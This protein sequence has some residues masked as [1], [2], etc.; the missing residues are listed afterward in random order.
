MLWIILALLLMISQMAVV[1]INEYCRPQKAVAWLVLLYVFPLVGFVAYGFVAKEYSRF[2]PANRKVNRTL[3]P[4]KEQIAK[5]CMRRMALEPVGPPG[6]DSLYAML[7]NQN[8][9]PITAGNQ[10]TVYSEGKEAFEAMFESLS[11]AK[12]H[13]HIEFYII[14][15]DGLGEKFQQLLIRKS[16][17]GVKVRLLYDGIGCHRLRKTY[18]QE[19]QD[20]GVETGC[21]APPLSAFLNKRINYRNHRKIVVVDGQVGFIGG[22]N[23]G[24]EYLGKNA[25]T[26]YWRD[27]HFKIQGDAALWIQY[28][29]AKDWFCVKRRLLTDPVYY[30]VQPAQ[31]NELIQIIKSGP[32]ET[33]LELIFTFVASAKKRIYIETPYFVPDSG[34]LLALK[35]AAMRGVDVRIVIPAVPDTKLVYWA[36]LSYVQ[37]MLDAG[38]RVYRYQKGFIHAKVIL[39]DDVACAGSAN[40]DMRSFTGQYEINAMF[41]DDQVVNRLHADFFCDLNECE[42]IKPEEFG[43]RPAS[44]KAKETFARLLSA[45]F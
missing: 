38:V 8:F 44:L 33:I 42:E 31:G 10:T 14:R 25:K 45:L 30:P 2:H 35:T 16:Q 28:T 4:L 32:D 41:F 7:Q 21:F 37:E 36:S 20:A 19:L 13:I 26:G 43:A 3:A 40:L 15:D 9:L 17:E 39:C 12:H 23:I 6:N 18:L 27:T 34:V 5:R 24:D 22:L 11:L 1:L 29:F